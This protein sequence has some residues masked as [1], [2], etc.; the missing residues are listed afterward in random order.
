MSSPLLGRP[1]A[2]AA[3]EGSPD[4]GVPW[5]FGDP[6]AEARTAARR[7]AVV[8]RSHRTIIA[9][10]GADR[11]D[12]LHSLTS[13]HFHQLAPATGS[14]ALVLDTQGRVEHHAVVAHHADTV[15]LDT[16]RETA[17]AL[18]S[19]LTKMVFWS[20]VE[21]RDATGELA[22]LT[23]L[24]PETG[25]VLAKAGVQVPDTAY[26]LTDLPGGFARR[27][28]W[29]TL[30][31]VDLLVPRAELVDW[32][33]RLADVGAR[34][35]GTLAYESLRVEALRPRLGQ[36]TDNRTIP[37]EVNWIGVAV[38]LD[39]GCYRGQE[40]V[41]RV[42]NLGRPPRRM[43]LLHLDGSSDAV[44]ETGDPVELD[45]RV[46]GRLG[47]VVEHHELGPI[48]LALLKQSVA[49]DAQLLAG[50]EGR[51]VAATIDPDSVPAA[52]GEPPGKA[53]LRRLR[54]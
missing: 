35:A 4:L 44:P 16:E 21:P 47:S 45:G 18:L 52:T 2:I 28:P 5:H 30:D 36:D 19:Y 26:G 37:Q 48:A 33:Q 20:K 24:G 14:E 1:G 42:H 3:P 49:V 46:V 39:K 40:T 29:P 6:P 15:Y 9:V 12:W 8:D 32:F 43:V 53:A 11:L 22:L 38:H 41:A 13:Q 34:P 10:P 25:E 7:A 17:P 54:G 23:V 50:A 51:V 31:V 27:M